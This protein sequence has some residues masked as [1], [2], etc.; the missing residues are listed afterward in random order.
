[1]GFRVEDVT[2][3]ESGWSVCFSR[4]GVSDANTV[5]T[6]T[7]PEYASRQVEVL[8]GGLTRVN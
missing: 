5:L 7:H 2:V 8:L 6:V 3:E 4:R 1:M